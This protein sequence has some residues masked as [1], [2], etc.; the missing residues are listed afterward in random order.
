MVPFILRF[1]DSA[2]RWPTLADPA[3]KRVCH[4]RGDVSS[5]T[6]PLWYFFSFSLAVPCSAGVSDLCARDGSEF[7]IPRPSPRTSRRGLVSCLAAS[8]RR[9]CPRLSH[10]FRL[11]NER[12]SWS[13]SLLTFEA[14]RMRSAERVSFL[15]SF[16]MM[17]SRPPLNRN[18]PS[19]V[20]G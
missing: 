1:F 3:V 4:E 17:S 8:S 11:A 6:G 2:R 18:Q 10:C 12:E 15:F 20:P 9:P 5:V 13:E 7:R 19:R 14:A 16:V